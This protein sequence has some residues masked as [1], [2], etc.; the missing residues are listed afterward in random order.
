[1]AALRFAL[2]NNHGKPIFLCSS[3]DQC[4]GYYAQRAGGLIVD[5]ASRRRFHIALMSKG[6]S[7]KRSVTYCELAGDGILPTQEKAL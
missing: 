2:V 3:V 5:D 4:V 6:W 7:I 1:M